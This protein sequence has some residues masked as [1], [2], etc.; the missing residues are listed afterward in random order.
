MKKLKK[1]YYNN[2][3]PAIVNQPKTTAVFNKKI[4]SGGGF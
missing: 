4:S 3:L 2:N 1:N